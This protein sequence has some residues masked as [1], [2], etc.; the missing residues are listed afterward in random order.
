MIVQCGDCGMWF[1]D[2]FRSTVCPHEAFPANDGNNNFSRHWDSYLSHRS[3]EHDRKRR[4]E[5]DKT[6]GRNQDENNS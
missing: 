1:E 3:P 2:V 6:L 4:A 5:I